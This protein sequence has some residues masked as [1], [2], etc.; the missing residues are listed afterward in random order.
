MSLTPHSDTFVSLLTECVRAGP[1]QPLYT[2]LDSGARVAAVL[3]G[4]D[5]LRQAEKIASL[6]QAHRITGAPVMV[7]SPYGPDAIV[8]LY[9]V[10]MAGCPAVPVTFHRRLGM[11]S[12]VNIISQTGLRVVIGRQSTLTKLRSG[13][14]ASEPRFIA[15]Q[16]ELLH[17]PIDSLQGDGAHGDG[18]LPTRGQPG[19]VSDTDAALIYPGLPGDD[20]GKPLV[21]SH[22]ALLGSVDG[23]IQK[24]SIGE[25]DINDHLLTALDLADGMALVMHVLLPVRAGIASVFFPVEDALRKS[26]PWL[27]AVSETGSTIVSV[28]PSS[29]SL[30]AHDWSLQLGKGPDLTGVRCFCLSGD[31]SDAGIESHFIERYKQ[32][33]MS[34]EK[35]FFC[36]GLSAT[37]M[38]ATDGWLAQG[39]NGLGCQRHVSNCFVVEQREFEAGEIEAFVLR[40]FGA[41]GLSRCLVLR[42]EDMKQTVLLAECATRQ[43][44]DDWQGVVSEIMGTVLASTGCQ[45]DRVILLRPASL[46]LAVSGIVL[47]QRCASALADGSLML[48]LLPVRGK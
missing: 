41:R 35:L 7:L 6:L 15:R 30:A 44:A 1:D 17:L 3:T 2:F 36:H 20:T 28:P 12:I 33:N 9:G 29:L 24:L 38:L 39:E 46:P 34:S 27:R 32:N 26:A 22:R 8:M 10:M 5:V 21:L 25:G 11:A 14:F 45:L 47:R 19:P 42:L 23:L 18:G 4:R 13:R 43:L 31:Y 48:R 40:S 37:G 16:H